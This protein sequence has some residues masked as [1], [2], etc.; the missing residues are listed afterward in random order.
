[1]KQSPL[2]SSSRSRRFFFF[3]VVFVLLLL[4]EQLQIVFVEWT[5]TAPDNKKVEDN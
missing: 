4:R 1:M 3:P 2:S 5:K